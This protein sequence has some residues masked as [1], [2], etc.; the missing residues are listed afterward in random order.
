ME[1]P[2]QL[3][4]VL[5]ELE[6]L[7]F[8]EGT[9]GPAPADDLLAVLSEVS[10]AS[11]R[12]AKLGFRTGQ[13][14]EHAAE[15]ISALSAAFDKTVRH[16]NDALIEL[17]EEIRRVKRE[18]DGLVDALIDLADLVDQATRSKAS[19]PTDE[20]QG[21]LEALLGGLDGLLTREGVTRV[22]EIGHLFDPAL[23]RAREEVHSQEFPAGSVLKVLRQGFRFRGEVRR[24]ADVV[25]S[26]KTV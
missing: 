10:K 17:R 8:P 11:Q 22:G 25:I 4:D 19:E 6:E 5:A 23:H 18:R 26:R 9:E 12:S 1:L 16:Q 15:Q 3:A 24:V 20:G 2:T 7:A 13:A 14:M 21:H